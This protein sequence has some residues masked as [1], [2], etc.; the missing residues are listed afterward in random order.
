VVSE[1]WPL[2]PK[3]GEEVQ[4]SEEAAKDAVKECLFSVSRENGGD[5]RNKIKRK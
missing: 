4:S 2:T 3:R 1:P 5:S